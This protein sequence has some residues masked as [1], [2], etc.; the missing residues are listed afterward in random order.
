VL[1]SRNCQ[2]FRHDLELH[3]LTKRTP[4]KTH[5]AVAAHGSTHQE[6]YA[7]GGMAILCRHHNDIETFAE[8]LRTRNLIHQ[9]CLNSSSVRDPATCPQRAQTSAKK[10]GSFMLRGYE[11]YAAVVDLGYCGRKVGCTFA[12]KRKKPSIND[13]DPKSDCEYAGYFWK[14]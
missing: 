6:R 1:A 14:N 9:L 11:G 2:I 7:L 4:M 10:R 13:Q 12:R 5:Q 3:G 8:L